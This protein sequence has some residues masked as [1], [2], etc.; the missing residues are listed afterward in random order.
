MDELLEKQIGTW[1]SEFLSDHK[2]T[3]SSY[4]GEKTRNR[5]RFISKIKSLV[6]KS[7]LRVLEDVDG[8]INYLKTKP[9]QNMEIDDYLGTLE[10]SIKDLKAELQQEGR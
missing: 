4:K 6:K 8:I 1:L 3:A 7:Q 9:F 2:Y 10:I 5:K